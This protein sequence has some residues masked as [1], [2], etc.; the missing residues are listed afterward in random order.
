MINKNIKCKEGNGGIS[1]IYLI[2]ASAI[3]NFSTDSLVIKRKYGNRNRKIMKLEIN[4][5][6]T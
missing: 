1:E 6:G 5:R 4:E 2:E 3:K